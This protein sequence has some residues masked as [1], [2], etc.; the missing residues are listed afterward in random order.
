MN[1][2]KNKHLTT[3]AV[4][5]AIYTVISLALAPLSYGNIQVRIAECLTLLPILFAPS[6]YGIILGCF[7]TNLIG[8]MMGVTL[9]GFLDVFIGTLA[10]AIAAVLTYKFKD[11]EL[12]GHSVLSAFMPVIINA[13]IIGAQ[14]SIV[15]YASEQFILGWLISGM[16]VAL[17]QI[18]A[19]VVFGLP[20][21][22]ALKKAKIFEK[23][24]S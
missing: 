6:I 14:L 23:F 22:K 3:I 11:I 7:L 20:L 4:I 19:C 10:T 18:V 16:Q 15:L 2:N 24:G 21:I 8:A 1:L 12:F 13:I 17:G 5:A 9:L